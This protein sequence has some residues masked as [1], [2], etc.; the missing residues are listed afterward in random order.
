MGILFSPLLFLQWDEVE[1]KYW[2]FFEDFG[3]GRCHL[4]G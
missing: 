3:N 1:V 4:A 2:Q